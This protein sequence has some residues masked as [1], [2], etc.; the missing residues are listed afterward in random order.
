MAIEAARTTRTAPS[1]A[2][3]RPGWRWLN[4]TIKASF[5]WLT[6]RAGLRRGAFDA[7]PGAQ[8][9]V[10]SDGRV[11]DANSAFHELFEAAPGPPLNRI[12][13]AAADPSAAAALRRLRAEAAAGAHATAALLLRGP[14]GAAPIHLRIS[15]GPIARY[16]GYSFW[17]VEDIAAK[18]KDIG[19]I[20]DALELGLFSADGE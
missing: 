7:A 10:A 5:G 16:P 12:E 13:Q 17:S 6:N 1:T 18:Y 4:V 15:L 9:I 14:D 20:L 2:P 11:V 19:A 3:P 8:L